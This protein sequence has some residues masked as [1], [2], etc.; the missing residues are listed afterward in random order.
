MRNL[1]AGGA[2]AWGAGCVGDPAPPGPGAGPGTAADTGSSSATGDLPD[3]PDCSPA[4]TIPQAPGIVDPEAVVDAHADV[5]GA[6]PAPYHVH[7]G[8]PSSDPST[9]I[10]FLWRT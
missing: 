4:I 2:A 5:L 7:L 8:W 1:L 3:G 6:A 9:S 10:S